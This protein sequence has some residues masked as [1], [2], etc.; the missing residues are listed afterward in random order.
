[1]VANAFHFFGTFMSHQYLKISR[2]NEFLFK[3]YE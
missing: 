1:M 3:R 2:Q